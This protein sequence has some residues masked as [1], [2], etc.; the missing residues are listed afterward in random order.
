MARK[1]E[2]NRTKKQ[3]RQPE[4][5]SA[6]RNAA[7]QSGQQASGQSTGQQQ[8]MKKGNGQGHKQPQAGGQTEQTGLSRREQ[9]GPA[10]GVS[11]FS[12]VRRFGEGMEELLGDFGFGQLMP[13]G[14]NQIAAWGPPVEMFERYGE[15][16]ILA[17]LPA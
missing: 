15:L 16:V 14:F 6:Q 17:H 2:N 1:K 11:P 13:Q 7:E 5:Q 10:M 3:G 8:Q 9:A 4:Q 12:F